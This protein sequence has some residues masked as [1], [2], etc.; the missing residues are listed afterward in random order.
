M[1]LSR[2]RPESRLHV[3]TSLS[4]DPSIA[5]RS[6]K[7]LVTPSGSRSTRRHRSF[8]PSG[9]RKSNETSPK[10]KTAEQW[11][12]SNADVK[13][14]TACM[15]KL[16]SKRLA[17]AW[18]VLVEGVL[19][20]KLILKRKR[21]K[22]LTERM[23]EA[24]TTSTSKP[25]HRMQSDCETIEA[26]A[27]EVYRGIFCSLTPSELRVFSSKVKLIEIRENEVLFLQGE[28]GTQFYILL[29]GKV[30][31]YSSDDT[32]KVGINLH[33]AKEVNGKEFLAELLN[34]KPDALG[35]MTNTIWPDSGEFGEV[36]LFSPD[37]TRT[38]TAVAEPIEANLSTLPTCLLVLDAQAY[39]QSLSKHH[40]EAFYR[41]Q[42]IQLIQSIECFKGLSYRRVVDLAFCLQKRLLSR[43]TVL[44][45]SECIVALR[46]SF[47]LVSSRR[48]RILRKKNS[49]PAHSYNTSRNG[50]LDEEDS[51]ASFKQSNASVI[52]M[53][54]PDDKSE[55]Q[56]L[57]DAVALG[58]QSP[59]VKD[60]QATKGFISSKSYPMT[61]AKA[62]NTQSYF[63][64]LQVDSPAI[65]GCLS[66]LQAI[67]PKNH[68]ATSVAPYE[69]VAQTQVECFY[70]PPEKLSNII[71]IL[72]GNHCTSKL[73]ALF[74]QRS[75]ICIEQEDLKNKY[76]QVPKPLATP[77]SRK[78]LSRPMTSHSKKDRRHFLLEKQ[79]SRPKTAHTPQF[80]ID[81]KLQ[82]VT[83]KPTRR[84]RPK[85]AVP[86]SWQ[87]RQQRQQQQ[88]E[89]IARPSTAGPRVGMRQMQS[90]S[91]LSSK[92]ASRS[93]SWNLDKRTS[94]ASE[95][96]SQSK[97]RT[98]RKLQRRVPIA[99]GSEV[100]LPPVDFVAVAMARGLSSELFGT[101]K[102]VAVWLAKRRSGKAKLEKH[103]A[104][105]S[106][107]NRV[108]RRA[109]PFMSRIKISKHKKRHEQD[110]KTLRAAALDVA[111][112]RECERRMSQ[113]RYALGLVSSAI[114]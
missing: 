60:R 80:N 37:K 78:S 35:R 107:G 50:N 63:E 48:R 43:N 79:R 94:L 56:N 28:T 19:A 9:S 112:E 83:E 59:D 85:S 12:W 71:T 18:R 111:L 90:M 104:S 55:T 44:S 97:S 25:H 13:N 29:E 27:K 76:F 75:T 36:A 98:L 103:E 99:K 109:R 105:T 89:Y 47:K 24:A 10:V 82:K 84:N 11:G 81:G 5:P 51:I 26:W 67:H 66:L 88:K 110:G 4:A 34:D 69:I 92:A 31:I 77:S 45:D 15:N 33:R 32:S 20:K 74:N 53:Q 72:S 52:G 65:L 87:Q 38:A 41:R 39:S 68:R 58:N 23:Y 61:V 14:M 22:K 3:N 1:S 100:L 106:N 62:I 73:A 6:I 95:L 57:T 49:T 54:A 7:S 16:I 30:S 102:S 101:P 86:K 40:S 108:A 93:L 17:S 8:S 21:H 70:L 2:R 96:T 114:R 46:G 91:S 64:C 113:H 42:K